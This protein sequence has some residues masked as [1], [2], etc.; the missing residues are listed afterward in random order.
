M[1]NDCSTSGLWVFWPD[2]SRDNPFQRMVYGAFPPGWTIRSAG[3]EVAMAAVAEGQ[4]PVVFHLHWEDVIYREAPNAAAAASL[5]DDYLTRLDAFF[6]AGGHFVWTVHNQAPH[7]VRYLEVDGK[8]RTALAARAHPAHMHSLIAAACMAPSLGISASRVLV[9]PLGGFTGYYPDDITRKQARRYFGLDEDA[10]VFVTVGTPRPYK[11]MEVLLEAF[12]AVHA[13]NPRARL[14]V[15]GRTGQQT[16]GRFQWLRPGVLAIPHYIDDSTIQYVMRAADF[17]VFAFR[18]V[19]VSSS[20][21]LAET[22]GLPVIV[23]DLPT[24][25]EMVEPSRNGLVYPTGDVG[26]LVR[27]LLDAIGLSATDRA[28][29][30]QG[31]LEDIRHRDWGEYTSALTEAALRESAVD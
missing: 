2:Y 10:P 23:P 12:A 29:L 1:R 22:F 31:A 25:R 16:L 14:I 30:G 24:L 9:T 3:L 18:R 27:T 19:M 15:A 20:V 28:T 6:A 17:G 4:R 5:V 7:E 21:L 8:L 11:G 26:A 13:A